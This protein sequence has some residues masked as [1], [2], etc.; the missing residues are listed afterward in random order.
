VQIHKTT[1]DGRTGIYGAQH[2]NG[3]F[4]N[5]G[6]VDVSTGVAAYRITPLTDLE[7]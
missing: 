2:L 6:I 7:A 1:E 4:A 5:N 3:Y